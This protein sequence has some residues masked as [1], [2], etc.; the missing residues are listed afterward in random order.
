V[1]SW[2]TSRSEQTWMGEGTRD[3]TTGEATGEHLR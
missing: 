3:A 1:R 2:L